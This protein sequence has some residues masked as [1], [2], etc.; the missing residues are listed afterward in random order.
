MAT[1]RAYTA[2]LSVMVPRMGDNRLTWRPG[3]ALLGELMKGE[4]TIGDCTELGAVLRTH[5]PM[6]ARLLGTS[7]RRHD[8]FRILASECRSGALTG[9][10][11]WFM[12]PETGAY[13]PYPGGVWTACDY[14]QHDYE[15]QDAEQRTLS[16]A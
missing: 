2:K 14:G 9:W 7:T 15:A 3:P 5:G 10:S 6:V 4:E 12:S 13:L 11:E 8:G 16:A 1:H